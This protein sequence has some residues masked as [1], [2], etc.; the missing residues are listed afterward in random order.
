MGFLLSKKFRPYWRQIDFAGCEDWF[1]GRREAG[2]WFNK[3]GQY[4][5]QITM[6]M[7]IQPADWNFA[8]S[9]QIP[10][11]GDLAKNQPGFEST[12]DSHENLA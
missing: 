11:S 9:R 3:C 7:P 1:A 12:I 5:Q 6:S 8:M 2:N 4:R 10:R